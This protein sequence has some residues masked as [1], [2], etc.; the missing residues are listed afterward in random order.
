MIKS[1]EERDLLRK[2]GITAKYGQ[3]R[4][5]L[6]LISILLLLSILEVF[7]RMSSKKSLGSRDIDCFLI[8]IRAHAWF[9]GFASD[10]I[11]W[12]T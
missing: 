4:D 3:R 7:S 1:L 2:D 8:N 9:D 6:P 10:E 12:A 11:D 5:L